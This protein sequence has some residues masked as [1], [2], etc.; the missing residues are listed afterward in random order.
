MHVTFTFVFAFD[1]NFKILYFEIQED[2]VWSQPL[3]S[4]VLTGMN[5][6]VT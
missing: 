1:R 3:M 6:V 5:P 2:I 4:A